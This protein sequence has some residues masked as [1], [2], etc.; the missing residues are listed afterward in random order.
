MLSL[1][2][3]EGSLAPDPGGAIPPDAVWLDLKDPSSEE[4][5]AVEAATGLRIPSREALAEVETSSRLRRVKAGLSVSTPMITFERSDSQLKPLGFL[6]SKDRLVTV[7]FHDLRAFD[8][9]GKRIADGDGSVTPS[10]VFL[11]ILE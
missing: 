2:G 6:L 10:E 9:A 8:S 1:H 4:A 5:A 7:R 3:P 11:V